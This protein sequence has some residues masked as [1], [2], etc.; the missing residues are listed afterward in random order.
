MEP[1]AGDERLGLVTDEVGVDKLTGRAR[2]Q[3]GQVG[4][5][6]AAECTRSTSHHLRHSVGRNWRGVHAEEGS[7][8]SLVQIIQLL[9]PLRVTG[10]QLAESL[11][12]RLEKFF[13]AEFTVA[14][15]VGLLAQREVLG[16]GHVALGAWRRSTPRAGNS[17][18]SMR[19]S[20][21]S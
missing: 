3:L 13:G 16:M 19:S 11:E 1:P 2:K 15:R 14:N 20:I 5:P 8:H 10:T 4:Q 12:G 7:R 18:R 21:S 17:S 9:P 6:L